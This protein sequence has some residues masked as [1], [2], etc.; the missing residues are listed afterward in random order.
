LNDDFVST[1]HAL[2][3]YRDGFWWLSDVASTNGTFVNN[4]RVTRPTALQWGDLIGIGRVKMR[5]EP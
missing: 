2:L 1:E 5:L 4:Q 3:A